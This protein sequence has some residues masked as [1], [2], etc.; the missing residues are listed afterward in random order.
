VEFVERKWNCCD[1][2]IAKVDA[3]MMALIEVAFVRGRVVT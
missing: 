2:I 3:A 1:S